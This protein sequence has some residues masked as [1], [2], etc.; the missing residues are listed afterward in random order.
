MEI[1]CFLLGVVAAS[2]Q[3]RPLGCFAAAFPMSGLFYL[4]WYQRRQ[5]TTDYDTQVLIVALVM[6]TIFASLQM[7]DVVHFD[8]NTRRRWTKDLHIRVVVL[9]VLYQNWT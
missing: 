4:V 2:L 3:L 5:E 7:L 8:C 6:D 9:L 1:Q